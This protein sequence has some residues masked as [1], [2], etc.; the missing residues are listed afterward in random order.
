VTRT[1]DALVLGAG[2][3]GLGTA[4]AL[5]E[6][7]LSV[8]IVDRKKPARETSYGNA[9]LI[10]AE[11]VMPYA[12]PRDLSVILGVLAGRSTDARLAWGDILETA[13]SLIRFF[14]AG[15]PSRVLATAAAMALLTG[16]AVPAYRR[17]AEKA[18]ALG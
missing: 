2:M 5:Q 10:Q 12:F 11:A 14:R 4:L 7:G 16:E 15:A 9:G 1:F 6:R 18:A 3:V 17:L 13:P 8:A